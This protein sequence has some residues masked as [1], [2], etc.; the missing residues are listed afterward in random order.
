MTEV[1]DDASGASVVPTLDGL[2]ASTR[3]AT[4]LALQ[5]ILYATNGNRLR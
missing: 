1:A 4:D 2:E 5:M 3:R